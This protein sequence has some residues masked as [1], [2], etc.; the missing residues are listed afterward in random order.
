MKDK[1]VKTLYGITA[2]VTF[3]LMIWGQD[4]CERGTISRTKFIVCFA[5]QFVALVWSL[6]QCG[7]FGNGKNDKK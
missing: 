2:F 6:A 3:C 4:L 5:V 7:V 1:T